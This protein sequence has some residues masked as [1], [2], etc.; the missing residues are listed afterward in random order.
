MYFIAVWANLK[1]LIQIQTTYIPLK[2]IECM[3]HDHNKRC[4]YNTRA[5]HG[6]SGVRG[7]KGPMGGDWRVIRD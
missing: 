3:D 5:V 1:H 2:V 7:D 6:D 4:I